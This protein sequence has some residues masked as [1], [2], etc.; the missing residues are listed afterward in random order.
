MV[1]E[2][3][4]VPENAEVEVT[5]NETEVVVEYEE[6]LKDALRRDVFTVGGYVMEEHNGIVEISEHQNGGGTVV[7]SDLDRLESDERFELA[8]P[9]TVESFGI[10]LDAEETII[11]VDRR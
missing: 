1:T 4:D 10:R 9:K 5:E 6:P 7:Q 3:I 11:V 2:T 8:K